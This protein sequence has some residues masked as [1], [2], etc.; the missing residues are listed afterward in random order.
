MIQRDIALF[1]ECHPNGAGTRATWRPEAPRT[2]P[3]RRFV[4]P[5]QALNEIVQRLP[6]RGSNILSAP[7]SAGHEPPAG[8]GRA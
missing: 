7:G 4:K 2:T 3:G 6:D 1:R 5:L 8:R